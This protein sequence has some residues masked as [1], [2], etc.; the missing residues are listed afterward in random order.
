MYVLK[1][2]AF[3]NSSGIFAVKFF[4]S[5]VSTAGCTCS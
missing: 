4:S 1:K 2:M 3:T 5:V